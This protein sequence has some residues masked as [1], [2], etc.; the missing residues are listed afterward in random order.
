MIK[1]LILLGVGTSLLGACGN[2]DTP[3]A[4]GENNSAQGEILEGTISDDMI[5]LESLKSTG[6][7]IGGDEDATDSDDGD[8]EN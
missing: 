5:P 6:P 7:R 1:R 4:A 2:D 8:E 3:Q